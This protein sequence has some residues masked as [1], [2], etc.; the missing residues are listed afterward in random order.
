MV[1][2]YLR[3][4]AAHRRPNTLLSRAYDLKAFFST[5]PKDPADVVTRDVLTFVT[6]QQNRRHFSSGAQRETRGARLSRRTIER[7]L[8]S[9]SQLFGYLMTRDDLSIDHNP[10]PPPDTRRTGL[11]STPPLRP[12]R[13]SPA[14][15]VPKEAE[16]ALMALATARDRAM[17]SAVLR[18]EL[19]RRELLGL[20]VS[21]LLP[22]ENH[23]HV[24]EAGGKAGRLARVS[25]PFVS[26]VDEY[27][28][29]ERPRVPHDW[30]FVVLRGPTRGRPM[31]TE[32]LESVLKGF[33]KR[34]GGVDNAIPPPAP[35]PSGMPPR[36][37]QSPWAWVASTG[38][39]GP[40]RVH[41]ST[42][43]Q[44]SLFHAASQ[45]RT[46]NPIAGR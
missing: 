13:S 28:A 21:D 39:F 11:P 38:D 6:E 31:S 8:A 22:E 4:L 1:D 34:A 2:D 19:D 25:E 20:R 33:R 14:T 3:N 5:V 16:R 29:R 32:A 43:V 10:V 15:P 9:V 30:L 41:L 26:A 46:E 7:Q 18:G 12:R 23:V 44:S 37:A 35:A 27:V 36:D 40:A 45:P 24:R 17:V 42:G